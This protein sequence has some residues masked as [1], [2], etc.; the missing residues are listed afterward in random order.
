MASIV[1]PLARELGQKA[2]VRVLGVAPG[3]FETGMTV[4]P[5]KK[6]EAGADP[7][8]S[9]AGSSK[10]AESGKDK[11]APTGQRAGFNREMVNYPMRMGKGEEFGRLVKDMIENPMLNGVV[12]RLDGGV[13]MPSRL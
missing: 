10:S 9:T 7:S 11:K 2:G 13:R 1:L 5:A 12:V 3:V 6:K 8:V 4:P